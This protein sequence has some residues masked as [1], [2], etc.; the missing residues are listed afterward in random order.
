[1]VMEVT[2][3]SKMPEQ[4]RPPQEAPEQSRVGDRSAMLKMLLA[5]PGGLKKLMVMGPDEERYVRPPRD[6]ELPVYRKSMKRCTSDEKYLRPTRWCNPREPLVVALAN[7]LGA[8]ELLDR[9]FAEAAYWWVKNNL[10]LEMRPLN[11]VSATLKRGT[12]MCYHLTSVFVA[13]CRAAGIKARYKTFNVLLGEDLPIDF[14]MPGF[15]MFN[16]GSTPEGEG[17]VCIDGKWVVGHVASP[18]TLLASMGTPLWALG[19]DVV[20]I[21]PKI[22]APAAVPGSE[23]HFESLSLWVGLFMGIGM[24]FTKA[25]MERANVYFSTTHPKGKKILEEAGG[26]QAYDRKAREKLLTHQTVKP[27]DHEELL[28]T[29]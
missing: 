17:E 11:G 20:D 1:M 28:F 13:L 21:G 5:S 3:V 26:Q 14:E 27:R 18:V 4:Q 8:Y 25:A 7:E 22:G 10:L 24:R 6:Y 12:G 15:E 29:E 2:Q 23:K 16:T 19:E 9:E